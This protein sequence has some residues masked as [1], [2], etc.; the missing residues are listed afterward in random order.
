MNFISISTPPAVGQPIVGKT[1][2]GEPAT[3]A[4]VLRLTPWVPA[5]LG[6]ASSL[7][8]TASRRYVVA[9]PTNKEVPVS[10]FPIQAPL[11][12]ETAVAAAG[13]KMPTGGTST[14]THYSMSAQNC[15]SE[16]TNFEGSRLKTIIF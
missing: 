5:T 4:P 10:H 8:T 12:A 11:K 13:S 2:A 16:L 14:C 6:F 1:P 15:N 3:T 9:Y 7:A